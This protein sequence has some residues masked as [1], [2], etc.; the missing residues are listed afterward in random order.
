MLINEWA[1]I[2]NVLSIALIGLLVATVLL[3]SVLPFAARCIKQ[4]SACRQRTTLWM[5][6]ATP[7]LVSLICVL[8]FMPSLF[9]SQSALWLDRLAHWHHPYVFYLDSWHS[10]ALL[11]F[12][13]AIAYVL[14][15]NGLKVFRHLCALEALTHLSRGK[16]CHWGIARDII[17]L[18]SQT[19][20][21]FTAGLFSPKCYVTTGL[22]EQFSETE[23]D[24]I[25]AHERAHIRHKDTQKKLLFALFA[26]LYPRAVVQRLNRIFSL[27][28]EQLADAQV[29][30]TYC[31]FDIAQTLV[32]AARIQ[33]CFASNLHPAMMSFF[34]ADDVDLRVRA[35]VAP[36]RFRSF[37]WACCLLAMVL[38]TI[39]SS[40][41][42]DI[43]HH[44]IEAVFS[45]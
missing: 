20:L 15:R 5:F 14:V 7:W 34:V 13:L 39:L 3:I 18:E 43:L 42:V 4:L 33:R 27:A 38:I 19:P 1:I 16:A 28:T 37:P 35:L 23:L 17:V 44:L 24:I 25:I 41:G 11:F 10:A 40:V 21:A 8:V 2:F 29:G 45:H 31:T 26:S 36:Q 9:Q 12:S 22:V 30:M 6:V 32:K